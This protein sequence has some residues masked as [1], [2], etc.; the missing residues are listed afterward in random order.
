MKKCLVSLALLVGIFIY[1]NAQNFKTVKIGKQVWMAENLNVSVPGSWFYNEDP[2]MGNKYG[3]LYTW[4]AARKSCPQGWHLPTES[5]WTQLID[6][7][8]GEDK[9]GRQLRMG[10]TSGFNAAFGGLTDV[11]NFRLSE[12]YGTFWTASSYD[13]EHAWYVYITANNDNV[14]KTYFSK[15]YGFSVRYVRNN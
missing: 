13:S 3:R 11:G 15:K 9:A 6:Y 14:T 12:M 1:S 7:L 10:G 8:G 4:E 5:D 2:S